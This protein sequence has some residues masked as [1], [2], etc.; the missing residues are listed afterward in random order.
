MQ[1]LKPAGFLM[2]LPVNKF[3]GHGESDPEIHFEMLLS[4]LPV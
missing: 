4:G 2:R 3:K 1:E